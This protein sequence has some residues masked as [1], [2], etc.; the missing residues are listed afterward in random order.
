[1]VSHI[2]EPELLEVKN[3]N[4]YEAVRL[5]SHLLCKASRQTSDTIEPRPCVQKDRLPE[6]SVLFCTMKTSQ[7]KKN[8]SSK[9]SFKKKGFL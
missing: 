9:V 3:I 8:F 7:T 2:V 6:D 1:M 5:W 4:V